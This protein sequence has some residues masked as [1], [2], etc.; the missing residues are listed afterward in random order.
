MGG[1]FVLPSTFFVPLSQGAIMFH[2]GALILWLSSGCSAVFYGNDGV[3]AYATTA[4]HCTHQV[5]SVVYA[6]RSGKR[7]G[8]RVIAVD[9]ARDI[10]LLKCDLEHV[11][12]VSCPIVAVSVGE[13]V[14]MIGYPSGALESLDGTVSSGV[15]TGL[16][17]TDPK[18]VISADHPVV[19]GF[20]GGGLFSEVG[21]AGV[22]T[23]SC[24]T[25]AGCSIIDTIVDKQVSRASQK[26][27][28]EVTQSLSLSL[29]D[30]IIAVIGY[31]MRYYFPG[32]SML[33]VQQSASKQ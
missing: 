16:A 32:S 19:G 22:V 14:K 17:G 21:L 20:S 33:T 6:V 25:G 13:P 12:P 10:A 5:G 2:L 27:G 23:H 7:F 15:I 1:S 4:A 24:P 8:C 30:I 11:G 3:H 18:R 9:R 29:R 31:V 28:D 26:V